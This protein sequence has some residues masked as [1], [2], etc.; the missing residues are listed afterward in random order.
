MAEYGSE[1]LQEKTINVLPF[2]D[3]KVGGR[4]IYT[5]MQEG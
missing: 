4:E 1:Y 2:F 5:Y 3:K